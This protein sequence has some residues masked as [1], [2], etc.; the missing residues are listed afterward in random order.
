[1][2][3]TKQ[4]L[5]EWRRSQ[6]LELF[7]SGKSMT[8][9]SEALKVDI[10]TVSRDIAR[11]RRQAISKQSEYIE[12]LPFEHLMSIAS[13]TKAHT[14]LWRLYEKEQDAKRKREILDS[15]AEV[16]IKRQILLGDPEQI[17][18]ALKTVSRIKAEILQVT[19]ES[20]PIE[21]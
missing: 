16:V 9:I 10:S 11:M 3:S 7:A 1:L 20:G 12:N 15:I 17:Q 8:A 19:T 13:I 21:N 5:K 18:R 2:N 6:V 4:S 14:E